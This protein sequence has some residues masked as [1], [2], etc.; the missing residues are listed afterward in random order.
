MQTDELYT[1]LNDQF[2]RELSGY[3]GE[4]SMDYYYQ[5]LDLA[6]FPVLHG[7]RIKTGR[8]YFQIDT[9]VLF[10][11]F[12]LI[13]ETKNLTG[14]VHYQLETGLMYREKLDGRLERFQDPMM[15]ASVQRHHLHNFLQVHNI[16]PIPIHTLTVFSN[17]NVILKHPGHEV[18]P[19]LLLAQNLLK[20]VPE[21]R[22]QYQ[23]EHFSYGELE[24]IARM[25][26]AAHEP[27][28]K[29]LVDKFDIHA[30]QVR[31]GVWCPRCKR[32][33]MDRIERNWL[34]G[35]CGLKD[36]N[37]H[38]T[39]IHEYCTIFGPEFTNLEM[40]EF[41]RINSKDVMRRLLVG[42]PFTKIGKSKGA[43]YMYES[44]RK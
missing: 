24:Q 17:P 4:K 37:A 26:V 1:I 34:C 15:Q 6:A 18:I 19:D 13:I 39:A 23:N 33:M 32:N 29:R 38:M 5:L 43:K 10:P 3:I 40:R 11:Q 22:K 36:P 44:G 8:K 42:G 31:K 35:T 9:L 16:A 41:L 27:N 2:Q 20:R 7:L 30:S 12:I 14:V 25:L 28:E 21:L